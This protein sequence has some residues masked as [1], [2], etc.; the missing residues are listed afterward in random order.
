MIKKL[1]NV[2]NKPE[3]IFFVLCLFWGLILTFINPPF[4]SFDEPEHFYK[5]Y[6]FS[7]GTLNYKKITSYTD[8]TLMFNEPKTFSAQIIPVSI[9][10]I[11]VEV[12]KL[13]PYFDENRIIYKP[14][15][16]TFKETLAQTQYKLDKNFKTIAV[17]MVPSYTIVSYVPHIIVLTILKAFNTAPVFMMFIM[18][19]CSLFLYTGLIYTAIKITPVKKFMFLLTAAAPLPLYLSATINTDHL[20]IGLSFLLTAYVLKLCYDDRI[21]KV[22]NKHLFIFFLLIFLICI[23]KFTY[24]PLILLFFILP[25]E[26]FQTQKTR[27]TAF[28]LTAIF[29]V[30][31]IILFLAYNIHIFSGIFSYYNKSSAEMISYI[32]H[33]PLSYP[34]VL[35][36]TIFINGFQYTQRML[37]DFGCSDTSINPFIVSGYLI[38]LI[39]HTMFY[40]KQKNAL[41]LNKKLILCF[42]IISVIFITLSANYITFE[43]DTQ[44]LIAGFKGRYILPV[45]PL[46]LLLFD[47]NNFKPYRFNFTAFTLFYSIVFMIVFVIT[48]VNRYY[49]I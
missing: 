33:N 2:F 31:Y 21:E 49:I 42:I 43:L 45:L 25:A 8:G 28:V 3:N 9:V 10:R 22:Q 13:N 1:K 37:A 41:T 4:M 40:D 35:I 11:V 23:A 18:R 6:S 32:L 26:K 16:I 36:K 12:R 27:I 48:L 7:E 34:A 20:V 30:V 17:H 39:I 24:L 14:S 15:K 5:I 47:N 46:F 44:N 19:L 38:L 29:C